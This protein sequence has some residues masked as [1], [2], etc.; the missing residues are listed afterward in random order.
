MVAWSENQEVIAARLTPGGPLDVEKIAEEVL[1][2]VFI[3][4]FIA[5]LLNLLF[6][7]PG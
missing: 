5:S 6:D 7:R 1:L 4:A 2:S 3:A